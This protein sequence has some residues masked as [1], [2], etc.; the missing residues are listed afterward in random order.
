MS[1]RFSRKFSSIKSVVSPYKAYLIGTAIL[2]LAIY[3][4]NSWTAW[5]ESK[6]LTPN[7]VRAIMVKDM[8]K[9]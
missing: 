1:P 8:E 3:S 5:L 9:I 4:I 6:N 7:A 2:M